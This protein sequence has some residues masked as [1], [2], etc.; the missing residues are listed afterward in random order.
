VSPPP[1][2][3][4]PPP[5]RP[6]TPGTPSLAG[7]LHA[8]AANLDKVEAFTPKTGLGGVA[9]QAVPKLQ[10]A[11]HLGG[12][13]A[14]AP[15]EVWTKGVPAALKAL[16]GFERVAAAAGDALAPAL[17]RVGLSPEQRMARRTVREEYRSNVTGERNRLANEPSVA[18][19]QATALLKD[20]DSQAAMFL[21]TK[22]HAPEIF[23]HLASLAPEDLATVLHDTYG[24]QVTPEAFHKAMSYADGTL[25]AAET[26]KI[27]GAAAALNEGMFGPHTER[28][29]AGYGDKAAV[30]PQ[31]MAD[32][33]H[34][35]AK[36]LEP[37]PGAAELETMR[38]QEPI[39]RRSERVTRRITDQMNALDET[40]PSR[41]VSD[42]RLVA[43][44]DATR[45]SI[46]R[47][48]RQ[49]ARRS[50]RLAGTVL[51]EQARNAE[52]EANRTGQVMGRAKERLETRDQ[53]DTG[54]E[55]RAKR[56][57]QDARR[58][59]AGATKAEERAAKLPEPKAA[60]AAAPAAEVPSEF[61]IPERETLR[62]PGYTGDRYRVVNADGELR[63]QWKAGDDGS[64][65]PV[66]DPAEAARALRA[67]HEDSGVQAYADEAARL[68]P[69]LSAKGKAEATAAVKR[70]AA[71]EA[72]AK[73][74]E[75][76][77]VKGPRSRGEVQS[78]VSRDSRLANEASK[79]EARQTERHLSGEATRQGAA[80][81]SAERQAQKASKLYDDAVQRTQ[82]RA[83]DRLQRQKDRL[84]ARLGEYRAKTTAKL[85]EAKAAAQDSLAA[86]AP[87]TRA[88]LFQAK[89]AATSLERLAATAEA[90][91]D[92]TRADALR[93]RIAALP[94]KASDLPVAPE[95]I[96]GGK[97]AEKPA[98][99]GAA[100]EPRLKGR[101]KVTTSRQ[102]TTGEMPLTIAG[103]LE[104][105]VAASRGRAENEFAPHL[106]QNHGSDVGA[107][108]AHDESLRG[109]TGADLH[110]ALADAGQTAWDPNGTG[111]ALAPK[112]V[113]PDS[114]VLPTVMYD[115]FKKYVP[116]GE[117][118]AA[119]KAFDRVTTFFRT[120]KLMNPAWQ[121]KKIAGDVFFALTKTGLKPGEILAQLP[122]AERAVH[123]GALSPDL[124]HHAMGNAAHGE[125]ESRLGKVVSK[126]FKPFEHADSLFR[127][128]VYRAKLAQGMSPNLAAEFTRKVAGDMQ[129]QLGPSERSIAKRGAT[130]YPWQKHVTKTVL[131]YPVQHPAGLIRAAHFG[132]IENKAHPEDANN[133]V[134]EMFNPLASAALASGE[135][136]SV[137]SAIN[138]VVRG[139]FGGATGGNLATG[140][141]LS[142]PGS[143]FG[144]GNEMWF[145]LHHPAEYA[146][147]VA[148]MLP[149][150]RTTQDI[151]NTEPG[152]K[153]SL[154]LRKDTGEPLR[155]G[156]KN[157]GA[158][159]GLK[160]SNRKTAVSRFLGI[161]LPGSTP[162][163]KVKKK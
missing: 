103:Q 100:N 39:L 68:A 137:G 157:K 18:A 121:T 14:N 88:V 24:G 123:E 124:A 84:G 109:K 32:R 96:H 125:A 8:A 2:R 47:H 144:A 12:Q 73:A 1:P 34:A 127:E 76:K 148:G 145:A 53:L 72:R 108:A 99:G 55:A 93:A 65:K 143:K 78:D 17:E 9:E 41:S 28:H 82:A 152:P 149:P 86:T 15:A 20:K 31:T 97:V 56:A 21:A 40:A 147:Y 142:T 58:L 75:I 102:K 94:T 91:G 158:V 49:E 71:D 105:S 6:S 153:G 132:D 140:R 146:K 35:E 51:K 89:N 36:P 106:Q 101:Q 95:Y 3:P 134:A 4:A 114:A 126:S 43:G 154:P 113:R 61:R 22:L 131:S 60:E 30:S 42:E 83:E 46:E 64:W 151:L 87:Q 115:Q 116:R 111:R 128:T 44:K 52:T 7:E 98:G 45:K 161:P 67:A 48:V 162:P 29:L 16:P 138:P 33:A 110:A 85:G 37:M 69:K 62:R 136:S 54:V 38:L 80:Q 155:G 5:P 130:F 141:A 10:T 119:L 92:V 81:A 135:Y 118:P 11:A 139:L 26:A 50:D 59:E 66:T 23:G 104:K 77:G 13:I 120:A 122:E 163:P 79:I 112:D 19:R 160:G 156:A 90:A 117:A 150:V 25:P 133:P 129:G 159:K 57:A 70:S 63:V 27:N 74:D 107:L